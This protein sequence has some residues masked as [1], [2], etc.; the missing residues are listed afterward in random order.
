MT[1]PR[2]SDAVDEFRARVRSAL[3][4]PGV[5][6][7]AARFHAPVLTAVLADAGEAE[8][9]LAAALAELV[10][11]L[12]HVGVPRG[13]QFVLLG[14]DPPPLDAHGLAQRLAGLLTVPVLVHEPDRAGFAA[15]KLATG[16]LIELD[17]ELREAEAIVAVGSWSVNPAGPRGGIAL[18]CPG[19]ATTSTRRA[20]VAASGQGA[21]AAWAFARQVERAV[22]VDLSVAWDRAYCVVVAGGRDAFA[23]H[24]RVAGVA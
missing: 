4:V 18:L 23:A 24:A 19:V 5:D 8:P 6:S 14:G 7:L 9:L 12:D 1:A 10:G 16:T 22:P 13:R 2:R 17:D 21:A 3:A 15:G 20:Y 11:A